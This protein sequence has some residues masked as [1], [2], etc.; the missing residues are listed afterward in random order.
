MGS[1]A[2]RAGVCREHVQDVSGGA[3][4][5]VLALRRE[6]TEQNFR[7]RRY[8]A[9]V[10]VVPLRP[11]GARVSEEDQ[12]TVFPHGIVRAHGGRDQDG[13]LPQSKIDVL[14]GHDLEGE[15][16]Q[17]TAEQGRLQRSRLFSTPCRRRV[18]HLA[19]TA[20]TVE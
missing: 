11:G 13:S 9:Q 3:R 14:G 17:G 19:L 4:R 8:S 15:T 16:T 10:G 2:V 18:D 6:R 7:G 1:A 5:L 20:R 12:P